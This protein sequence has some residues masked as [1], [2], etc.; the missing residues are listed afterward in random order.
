MASGLLLLS[1][2]AGLLIAFW[3]LGLT[4]CFIVGSIA[5]MI[6]LIA[7][8]ARET[9]LKIAS[10][11]ALDVLQLF[12][13]SAV[14]LALLL[15]KDLSTLDLGIDD[16]KERTL[17]I[18]EFLM[19]YC[20]VMCT[21]TIR[22]LCILNGWKI[23]CPS[24]VLKCNESIDADSTFT[25]WTIPCESNAVAQPPYRG[26]LFSATSSPTMLNGPTNSLSSTGPLPPTVQYIP[27]STNPIS[28][29]NGQRRPIVSWTTPEPTP[30]ATPRGDIMLPTQ[31]DHSSVSHIEEIPRFSDASRNVITTS[32]V[33]MAI[34]ST[35]A[36]FL[37]LVAAHK[38]E[39][40]WQN[41]NVAIVIPDYYRRL[42]LVLQ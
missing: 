34:A 8:A 24:F 5:I 6:H 7:L 15:Y 32:V 40:E 28:Q 10:L 14:L 29:C 17:I 41:N 42:Q 12:I 11:I 4:G 27:T 23:A 37:Q 39:N 22:L 25:S 35:T 13:A 18:T 31:T 2:R 16:L 33:P 19:C 26:P 36:A 38:Q 9:R 20:L 30:R 3:A 21:N 1:F